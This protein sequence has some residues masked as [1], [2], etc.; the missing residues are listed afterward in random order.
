MPVS[1]ETLHSPQDAP[2]SASRA[3]ARVQTHASTFHRNSRTGEHRVRCTCGW[4]HF[5]TLEDCQKRAAT[6][7]FEWLPIEEQVDQAIALIRP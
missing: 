7:D 5:G 6:H 3:Q 4:F 2:Q 1:R